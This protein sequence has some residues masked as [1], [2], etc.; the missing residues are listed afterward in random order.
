M[1]SEL[2]PDGKEIQMA[3]IYHQTIKG[4]YQYPQMNGFISVRNY[5]FTWQNDQRCLLLR[6]VNNFDQVIN[7]LEFTITQ[8]DVHGKTIKNTT[9]CHK[10]LNVAQ[11]A[12]YTPSKAILVEDGCADFKIS[13]DRVCSGDYTYRV[14]DDTLVAYYP[15]PEKSFLN[16]KGAQRTIYA[17]SEQRKTIGAPR[18]LYAVAALALLL[19]VLLNVGYVAEPYVRPYFVDF[20]ESVGDFFENVGDGIANGFESIG[21]FIGDIFD[22][23]GELW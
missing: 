14:C 6:F 19:V 4:I 2:S 17:F 3:D 23:I 1:L 21:E 9:V 20:M 5:I 12:L 8:L 10:K 15:H 16:N 18:F 22:A 13:F 11:G 7:E